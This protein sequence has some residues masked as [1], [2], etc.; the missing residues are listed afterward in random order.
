MRKSI[1]TPVTGDPKL[2]RL[3]CKEIISDI[4]SGEDKTKK[5]YKVKK[6]SILLKK[7]MLLCVHIFYIYVSKNFANIAFF[8]PSYAFTVLHRTKDYGAS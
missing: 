3:N 5:Y 6:I 8:L 1:A 4:P 2:A 7:S